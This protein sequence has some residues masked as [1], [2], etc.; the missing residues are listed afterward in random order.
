MAIGADY[1]D[2]AT[3]KT[4][5]SLEVSTYDAQ[6]QS[7]ISSASREVERFCHRQF[8][9]ETVATPRK[10]KP[11]R[12]G[13]LIVDDF[14]TNSG[15]VIQTDDDYDGVFE[16][17]WTEGTDFELQPY[18]GIVQGMPGFPYWKVVAIGMY[19]FPCDRAARVQVTAQWGWSAVPTPVVE[20][21]KMLASDVF[22]YKDTRMGVAGF[23]AMGA[24]VRVRDNGM[25]ASKLKRYRR[26]GVLQ[27]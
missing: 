1:T 27:A 18:N 5:M 26:D 10:Y 9:K 20:A 13:L 17:T 23:D 24:V 8:N 15:L 6:L 12:K 4:Y 19:G 25:A 11:L 14:W 2:L 21:T 7:V 22:Q 3:L 16:H